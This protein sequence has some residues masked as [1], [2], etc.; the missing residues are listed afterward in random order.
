MTKPVVRL[1]L[2]A[3]N[4]RLD[5][6]MLML[7]TADEAVAENARFLPVLMRMSLLKAHSRLD[8]IRW[9]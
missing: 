4:E 3:L 9:R 2:R 6:M 8:N 1:E 7:M 5:V